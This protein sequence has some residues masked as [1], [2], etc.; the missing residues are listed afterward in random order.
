[1][2]AIDLKVGIPNI[3]KHVIHWYNDTVML[4]TCQRVC[5]LQDYMNT[6][7]FIVFQSWPCILW[8]LCP[9]ELQHSGCT[10]SISM[11]KLHHTD[12]KYLQNSTIWVKFSKKQSF[13]SQYWYER[14]LG[15]LLWM[16]QQSLCV[17]SNSNLW[18]C[19]LVRAAINTCPIK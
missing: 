15:I 9:T 7:M 4:F 10:F 11:Q 5:Q 19:N 17:P 2:Q 12:M 1:M 6:A 3:E 13:C 8:I 14:I 18:N 16:K